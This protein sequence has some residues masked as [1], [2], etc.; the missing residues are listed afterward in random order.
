MK[1]ISN[2]LETNTSV[3]KNTYSVKNK[4]TTPNINLSNNIS[5]W[6]NNDLSK[7]A[8][9]NSRNSIGFSALGVQKTQLS[10]EAEYTQ[11]DLR[12]LCADLSAALLIKNL[13]KSLPADIKTV[14]KLENE[15]TGFYGE[16]YRID[17]KTKDKGVIPYIFVT[18]KGTDDLKDATESDKA[19]LEG[20][21][22][23]QYEDAKKL[24]GKAMDYCESENLTNPKIIIS[25][26]SLGG[27]L[28]QLAAATYNQEGI[29]YN[30]PGMLNQLKELS[31]ENPSIETNPEKLN[32]N[33]MNY[34][35]KGDIIGNYNDHAGNIK[36]LESASPVLNK[37]KEIIIPFHNHLDLET[38][39]YGKIIGNKAV[40]LP[41][42][43]EKL[44]QHIKSNART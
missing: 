6:G 41:N 5:L 42:H 12:L 29:A 36:L 25:G 26:H 18:Y 33:I 44:S 30:G 16:V 39:K 37:A 35:V 7:Q 20:K 38:L 17:R 22:P 27:A 28:A 34:I 14:S 43:L 10:G 8:S 21:I 1:I 23:E 3:Q 32:K 24:Y 13:K 2:K 9:L 40:P 19:I 31:N 15:K 11:N 4:S